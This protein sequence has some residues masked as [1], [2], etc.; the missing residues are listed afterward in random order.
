M[1]YGEEVDVVIVVFTVFADVI[2]DV[3]IDAFVDMLV[4]DVFVGIV[5]TKDFL[6]TS[7]P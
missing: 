4:N 7:N 6:Y 2:K 5:V 1:L 3:V